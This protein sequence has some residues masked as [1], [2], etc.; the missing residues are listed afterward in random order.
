MYYKLEGELK[1][2][3]FEWLN[4]YKEWDQKVRRRFQS[5]GV[6]GS[7]YFRTGHSLF[8]YR[9][10]GVVSEKMPKGWKRVVGYP[11]G[12]VPNRRTKV[13]KQAE[14]VLDELGYE[15]KGDAIFDAIGI[16]VPLEIGNKYTYPGIGVS[17]LKDYA[18]LHW[19]EEW[20][21]IQHPDLV[22]IT[23]G[24]YKRLTA[25]EGLT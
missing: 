5:L 12:W 21:D 17:A 22:E 16:K 9:V 11:N 4:E 8:G 10:G 6:D 20:P 23:V 13:G 15:P 19:D 18:V 2:L 1:R 25:K 24:E 14:L 3:A 7:R